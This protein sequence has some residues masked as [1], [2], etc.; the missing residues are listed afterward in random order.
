MVIV[1][2]RPGPSPSQ[3]RAGR[4]VVKNVLS[5]VRWPSGPA[6]AVKQVKQQSVPQL[7]AACCAGRPEI[8]ID[9]AWHPMQPLFDWPDT[10]LC[11]SHAASWPL[12][13]VGGVFPDA[14]FALCDGL[15]VQAPLRPLPFGLSK[16]QK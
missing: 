8:E 13:S 1:S 4:T 10:C 15:L 14:H 7:H 11:V 5:A 6:Q 2:M 3:G 12:D 16:G 9:C